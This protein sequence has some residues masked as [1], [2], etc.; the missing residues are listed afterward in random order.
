MKLKAPE[1]ALTQQQLPGNRCNA[2]RDISKTL[3]PTFKERICVFASNELRA[4]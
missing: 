4:G 3:S 2:S 1:K